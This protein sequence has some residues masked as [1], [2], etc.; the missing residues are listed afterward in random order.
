[1]LCMALLYSYNEKRASARTMARTTY[2]R[3]SLDVV[4]RSW[5]LEVLT[6]CVNLGCW[7]YGAIVLNH[8]PLVVSFGEKAKIQEVDFPLGNDTV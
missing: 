7:G 4:C 3:S 8:K 1:V 2:Y 5:M 6:L